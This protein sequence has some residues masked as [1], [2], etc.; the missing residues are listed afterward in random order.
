MPN[1]VAVPIATSATATAEE[2]G[3]ISFHRRWTIEMD[4]P[5]TGVKRVTVLVTLNNAFMNP[6][7]SFQMSMVR[8]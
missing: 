4:Q 3:T 8:P 5:V 7:V 2:T 1:G 6:G